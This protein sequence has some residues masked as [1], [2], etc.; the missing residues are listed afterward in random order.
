LETALLFVKMIKS[1]PFGGIH[2]T[3]K[4]ADK[5]LD[6]L[7]NEQPS[8]EAHAALARGLEMLLEY[9]KN[10]GLVAIKLK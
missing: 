2:L 1:S 8:Q 6:Q 10:N 3:G 5:F 7:K 9:E 4:D